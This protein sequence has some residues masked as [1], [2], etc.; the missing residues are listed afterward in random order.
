MKKCTQCQELK[1][2]NNFYKRRLSL[3]NLSYKCKICIDNNQ[4]EFKLNNPDRIKNTHNK[5]NKKWRKQNPE[6]SKNCSNNWKKRNPER[7]KEKQI[8]NNKD[9]YL[10]NKES[11]RLRNK[12]YRQ[13]NK[14][15]CTEYS[16]R[17]GNKYKASKMKRVPKWLTKDM[18]NEIKEIYNNCPKGYHVDHIIP[19]QGK[20]VSGL[21]LPWN[22]QYLPALDNIKKGNRI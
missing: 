3:D 2:F 1:S 16:R 19:L 7:V 21:H 22:L 17:N 4:Q 11:E 15:K 9:Y 5:A 18:N 6:I 8:Q 20:N 10:K 12:I 14:Q 13:N